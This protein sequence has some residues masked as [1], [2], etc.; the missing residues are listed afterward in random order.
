MRALVRMLA[1]AVMLPAAAVAAEP[2]DS[3]IISIPPGFA[4]PEGQC[5]LWFPARP[6]GHQPDPVACEELEGKQYDNVYLVVGRRGWDLDYDWQSYAYGNDRRVPDEVLA[7]QAAEDARP[8]GG[9]L[10]ERAEKERPD[11]VRS[12]APTRAGHEPRGDDDETGL[13]GDLPGAPEARGLRPSEVGIPMGEFPLG[14][15]CRIWLAGANREDQPPVMACSRIRTPA[16]GADAYLLFRDLAWD[17]DVDWAAVE[18]DE[19]GS[20]PD[21]VVNISRRGGELPEPVRD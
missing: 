17:L 4:P 20:V 11:P 12:G 8:R 13:P 15:G 21:P 14:P 5:R 16:R 3:P 10:P 6:P 2:N 1:A 19:P 9:D 18:R 7:V